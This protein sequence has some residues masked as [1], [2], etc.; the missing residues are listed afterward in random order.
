MTTLADRFRRH[1][2]MLPDGLY[3]TL[4]LAMAENWQAG[5]VVADICRDWADAPSSAVV[6]L[7]LMA[8]IQRLVLSR[9]EPQLAM[10]YPNLGGAASPAEA[11]QDFEPVLRRHVDELRAALAIA[12][13][14]NEPGRAVPLLLGLF[15]AIRRSGLSSVRLFELGASA[16]LNLLVDR[17][18]VAG[19]GWSYGPPASPLRLTEAVLG[20]VTPAPFTVVDRRGCDLA[21]IDASTA[22]G[23]LRL[24]S[25][26]WPH[27]LHRYERL[28]AA[29]AIAAS[30]PVAVDQAQ[31]SSW[32]ASMLEPAGPD[33]ALTVVWHS[34]TRQYWPPAEVAATS[35]VLDAAR[36]RMPIAHIAMESPVFRN[37]RSEGEPEY[38]PAEL[39]VQLS[40]PGGPADPAPVLLGT[41]ADHGVPVRLA[42]SP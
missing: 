3:R 29:L 13:Q 24:T 19:D 37:D 5:G 34:I 18:F 40:A 27:D 7:R 33:D 39:T 38:R 21:P 20:P 17:F 2:R 9:T 36:D 8:G 28:R 35:Q 25:F 32:L 15:D 14:T 30:H 4:M 6:Q 42:S 10:Y 23:R 12:P 41:V 26:V 16:G 31:A 22:E 11:W 1:A